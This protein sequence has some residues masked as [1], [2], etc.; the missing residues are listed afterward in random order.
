MENDKPLHEWDGGSIREVDPELVGTDADYNGY[1]FS[2]AY[3]RD[4]YEMAQNGI[5]VLVPEL[6]RLAGRVKEL[7]AVAES[8]EKV[9]EFF[10]I[11]EGRIPWPKMYQAL[12]NAKY[13]KDF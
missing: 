9:Y 4:P 10:T 12:K 11:G 8:A 6:T 13:L 3:K 2:S 5:K 1:T 7:E